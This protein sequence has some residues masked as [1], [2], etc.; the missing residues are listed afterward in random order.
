MNLKCHGSFTAI[1]IGTLLLLN[2]LLLLN[3]KFKENFFACRH[4]AELIKVSD[5]YVHV[6]FIFDRMSV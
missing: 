5:N 3:W 1:G 4:F 6:I 2:R